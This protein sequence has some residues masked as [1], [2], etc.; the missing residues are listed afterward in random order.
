MIILLSEL[1]YLF[2]GFGWHGG[3]FME[4]PVFTG[5]VGIYTTKYVRMEQC[6]QLDVLGR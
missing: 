3:A 2:L 4:A 5:K 1:A 6:G